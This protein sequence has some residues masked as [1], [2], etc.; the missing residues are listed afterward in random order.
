MKKDNEKIS[1]GDWFVPINYIPEAQ[2]EVLAVVDNLVV[3]TYFYNKKSQ[4][5]YQYRLDKFYE[6]FKKLKTCECCGKPE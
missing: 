1:A 2:Y 4:G 3:V 5:C 6:T